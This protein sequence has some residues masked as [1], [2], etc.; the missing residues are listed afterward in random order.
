MHFVVLLLCTNKA[1]GRCTNAL[2]QSIVFITF[3][4]FWLNLCVR[5]FL[6]PVYGLFDKYYN[7]TKSILHFISIF[8]L[9]LILH[10]LLALSAQAEM[11]SFLCNI[12]LILER[13]AGVQFNS[14]LQ[15]SSEVK[16]TE[17]QT[18][19]NHFWGEQRPDRAWLFR[20]LNHFKSAYKHPHHGP[21][22]RN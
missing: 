4:L 21:Q 9:L 16:W 1:F 15:S 5:P 13:D 6:R 19:F 22:S 3:Y 2:C 14:T 18:L 7:F 17:L 10:G 11:Y 20:M 12:W 8:L